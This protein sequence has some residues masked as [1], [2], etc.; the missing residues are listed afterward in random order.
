[1]VFVYGCSFIIC[2][3]QCAGDYK[4]KGTGSV[5]YWYRCLAERPNLK[6]KRGNIDFPMVFKYRQLLK[7]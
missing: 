1:M 6:G 7:A 4:G 3:I 2:D 5:W